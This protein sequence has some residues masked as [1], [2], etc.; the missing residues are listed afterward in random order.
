MD[1]KCYICYIDLKETVYLP[2][3]DEYF[4]QDISIIKNTFIIKDFGNFKFLYYCV[5][6][7]CINNYLKYYN[8]IFKY[9]RNREIG[10]K[11]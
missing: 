9:I 8:R 10:I 5:C 7:D 11:K 4:S 3:V 1:E 6:N 2:M